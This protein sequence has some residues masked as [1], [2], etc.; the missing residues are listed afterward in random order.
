MI[1][2]LALVRHVWSVVSSYGCCHPSETWT[3]QSKSSGGHHTGQGAEAQGIQEETEKAFFLFIFLT[4]KTETKVITLW[5]PTNTWSEDTKKTETNY[6]EVQCGR[7]RGY[8]QEL[9]HE[10]F[11]LVL[12]LDTRMVEYQNSLLTETLGTPSLE[13]FKTQL[14]KLKRLDQ[15]DFQRCLST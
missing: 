10:K 11:K 2:P 14:D 1:R 4:W 13:V 8:G 6:L 7:K 15:N 9:E 5:L 12:F 3:C